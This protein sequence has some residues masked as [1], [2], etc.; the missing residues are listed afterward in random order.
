M[1]KLPKEIELSCLPMFI[2]DK[3]NVELSLSSKDKI[4]V[5][6]WFNEFILEL[7][8]KNISYNLME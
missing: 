4:L 2:D 5:Y 8:N 1:Q 7:K 6:Q 3:P